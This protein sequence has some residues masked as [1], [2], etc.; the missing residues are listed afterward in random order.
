MTATSLIFI[1]LAITAIGIVVYWI[2]T[3]EREVP[4]G[5]FDRQ[6]FSFETAPE[7]TVNPPNE[8]DLEPNSIKLVGKDSKNLIAYWHMEKDFLQQATRDSGIEMDDSNNLYL[9]LYESSDLLRYH[10]IHV[11][12]MKGR[13]RFQLHPQNAYYV[14]LGIMNNKRFIPILTSN[15]VMKQK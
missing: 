8:I 5:N 2:F 13:C 4:G 3:S 15:T 12:K 11:N 9:R 7:L 6:A 10:D 1:L 14:S